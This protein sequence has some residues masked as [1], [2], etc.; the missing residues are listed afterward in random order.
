M[1]KCDKNDAKASSLEKMA[2]VEDKECLTCHAHFSLFKYL[3]YDAT[4]TIYNYI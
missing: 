3:Y 2:T 4:A 1:I